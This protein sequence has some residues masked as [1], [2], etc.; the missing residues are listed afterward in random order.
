MIDINSNQSEMILLFISSIIALVSCSYLFML[1]VKT[2]KNIPVIM[3]KKFAYIKRQRSIPT[4]SETWLNK[5]GKGNTF[6]RRGQFAKNKIMYYNQKNGKSSIKTSSAYLPFV[7]IIVPAR[8]ESQNIKRCITSLLKQDYPY[9][10]IILVDDNSTDNTVEIIKKITDS[11]KKSD[12]TQNMTEKIKII[13]LKNKPNEWTGK[14]WAAQKGFLASKGEILLFTDADTYYAKNDVLSQSLK[15]MEKE[16]LDVLTSSFTSEPLSNLFSKITIPIWDFVSI[17]FG[18][19]SSEVNNHKSHIAYLMGVFFLIKRNIFVKVGTF[20][21]VRD[22]IQEDKALGII[23][24]KSGYNL[25][26][27]NLK[28][29]VYTT[30][31][32]DMVTLWRGI[33][34]TMVPLVMRNK[35]KVIANLVIVLFS[36]FV[37]FVS[38]PL[39]FYKM[40]DNFGLM[41]NDGLYMELDVLSFVFTS[42]SCAILVYFFFLKGKE[43]KMSPFYSIMSPFAT[44]FVV[45]S[46]LHSI[47]PLLIHG[48]SRPIIWQGRPYIYKREQQGF[49]F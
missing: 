24:K 9:F 32:D 42:L 21:I 8:N 10:E 2:S 26:L 30:W 41:V 12:T 22:E 29:M 1:F 16:Q 19:G 43:Y 3:S 15:Y 20:E 31:A 14:T 27:V 39:L 23:I 48:N 44:G 40:I 18:V 45:I 46:C 35:F 33:G 37:P 25:K 4:N 5:N 38:L 28:E 34:R 17:L 36:A 11:L 6:N 7:S 13:S 49:A 47:V